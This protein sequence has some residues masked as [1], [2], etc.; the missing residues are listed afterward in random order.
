MKKL[1]FAIAFLAVAASAS[2]QVKLD[3]R[4]GAAVSQFSES[5]NGLKLGMKAGLGVEIG[6]SKLFAIRPGVYY[7]M[8]GCSLDNS[9]AIGEKESFNLSYLEV[10]VLA[11]FRFPITKKFE[12]AA[13]AGPYVGF[14]LNKPDGAEGLKSVD[15]GLAVGLDF[16]FGRFLFGPEV[17]YGLINVAKEGSDKNVAYFLSVGYKF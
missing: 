4:L 17:E 1:L 9:F 11:S 12:L 14:R 3:A 7:A 8:K 16:V 13:N 2:A 6:F 10:P 5:G 15:F